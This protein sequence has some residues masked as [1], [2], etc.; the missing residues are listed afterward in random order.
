MRENSFELLAP[1]ARVAF[2]GLDA[3]LRRETDFLPF[4][5]YRSPDDQNLVFR[6]GT[7][8]ARAF[9]SPHQY[10]L[11]VDFV[12]FIDGVWRWDVPAATWGGLH[13]RALAMGL[14]VPLAWD[15]PHIEHPNWGVVRR[16][17]REKPAL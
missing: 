14:T 17:T 11:A 15:K 16:F 4:E 2:L 12:P 8:K 1:V 3:I 5:T 7:S 9:E 6:K 10:G 13:R